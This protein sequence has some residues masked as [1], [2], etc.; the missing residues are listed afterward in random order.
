M[1]NSVLDGVGGERTITG[2]HAHSQ[3]TLK[4]SRGGVGAATRGSVRTA[5]LIHQYVKLERV[6]DSGGPP[7]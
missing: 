1:G 4:A 2:I 6:R 5:H 7:N 3:L